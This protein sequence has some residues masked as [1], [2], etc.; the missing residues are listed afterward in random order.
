MML[1]WMM[2]M[3]SVDVDGDVDSVMSG[4]AGCAGGASGKISMMMIIV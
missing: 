2:M 3:I 1:M 4:G